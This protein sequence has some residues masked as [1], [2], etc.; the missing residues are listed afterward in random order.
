LVNSSKVIDPRFWAKCR[1]SGGAQK[2]VPRQELVNELMW[3][4]GGYGFGICEVG[5]AMLWAMDEPSPTKP[6][7]K[8]VVAVSGP[9]EKYTYQ[10]LVK[11]V[12]FAKRRTAEYDRLFTVRRGC[13][14]IIIDKKTEFG[15]R[16]LRKRLTWNQ[17][18][19]YSSTLEE[20]M[21][22]FERKN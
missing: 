14:L 22:T 15:T 5:N 4:S 2:L 3:N 12:A 10:E 16:W 21:I 8:S 1:A 11:L 18:P 13:N 19:M 7:L 17:G 20:A 6:D 9:P